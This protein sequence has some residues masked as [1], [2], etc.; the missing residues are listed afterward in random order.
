MLPAAFACNATNSQVQNA[1]SAGKC[2]AL[3]V[4]VFRDCNSI[5]A[6]QPEEMELNFSASQTGFAIIKKKKILA[7]R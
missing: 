3:S 5:K 4:S 7:V 2:K 1:F 6:K